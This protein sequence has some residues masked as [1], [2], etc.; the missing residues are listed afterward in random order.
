M[1]R[2]ELVEAIAAVVDRLVNTRE[3]SSGLDK[4]IEMVM[5]LSDRFIRKYVS[6]YLDAYKAKMLMRDIP[7]T[8]QLSGFARVVLLSLYAEILEMQVENHD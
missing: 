8:K 7:K 4:A 6:R 1:V 5:G 2:G 3:G